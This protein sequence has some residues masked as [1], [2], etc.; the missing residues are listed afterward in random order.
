MVA[1]QQAVKEDRSLR[2]YI[3][4]LRPK[5]LPVLRVARAQGLIPFCKQYLWIYEIAYPIKPLWVLRNLLEKTI[6]FD[7]P[8]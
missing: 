8:K 1:L 5:L 2:R 4:D 6:G 7:Y 3:R